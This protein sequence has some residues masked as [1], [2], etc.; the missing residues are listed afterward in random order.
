MMKDVSTLNSTTGSLPKMWALSQVIGKL[1]EKRDDGALGHVTTDVVA[2]DM[3]KIAQAHGRD[4][5]NY[6]GFSYVLV[7]RAYVLRC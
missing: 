3:L 6:W 5:V 7:C 2:R 4:K 1:A